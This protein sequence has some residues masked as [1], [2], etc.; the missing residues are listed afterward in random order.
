MSIG[1]VL[2]ILWRRGWIAVL[3]LVA[4]VVVA[5]G[6][7]LF[8]PGRYDATATASIDISNADPINSSSLSAS[9][10]GLM[11]GNLAQ[12]V[13]S[14]R[15]AVDVVKRLNLTANPATQAAY[16]RSDCLAARVSTNGWRAPYPGM[17]C[18]ALRA[19]AAF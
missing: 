17:S 6:V 14:Q 1:Q 15:V 16:R 5:A 13:L 9:L 7:L 18:R 4:S 10:V 11:E 2:L 19:A 3:A 12:L 8:I